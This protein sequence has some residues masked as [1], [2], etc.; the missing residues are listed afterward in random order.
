MDLRTIREIVGKTQVHV[1][2]ATGM[3]QSEISR[4][5]RCARVGAAPQ[6]QRVEGGAAGT[7]RH[8]SL[9]SLTYG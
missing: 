2:G 9:H 3:A 1:A 7:G 5:E 4:L 6:S 8:P